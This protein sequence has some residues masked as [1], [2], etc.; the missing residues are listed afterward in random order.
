M[1]IKPIVYEHLAP[2]QRLIAVFE[3][4]GRDDE[5]EVHRL[6]KSCPKQV[7]RA[8]DLKFTAGYERILD[9]AL[10]VEYELLNLAFNAMV[11]RMDHE[12]AMECLQRMSDLNAVWEAYLSEKGLSNSIRNMLPRN[13]MV[14]SL[15][16]DFPPPDSDVLCARLAEFKDSM[17]AC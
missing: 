8:S 5:E 7:Y 6:L 13:P 3:A 4:L 14:A 17:H 9:M 10:S 12:H 15:L 1:K 2:S 11:L 16:E